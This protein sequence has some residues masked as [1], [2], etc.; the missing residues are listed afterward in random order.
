MNR[1]ILRRVALALIALV[2]FA[3]ASV[4]LAA[5]PMERGAMAQ[6][7]A[8]GSCCD[9]TQLEL[10][11]QLTNGCVAHCT[12]DLQLW[13]M[14]VALVRPPADV[15]VLFVPAAQPDPPTGAGFATPPL[16]APPSR[17]L[18]HSFLI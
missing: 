18:L 1:R 9:T 17:I 6:A 4:A 10:Q 12:A 13:A 8:D 7:A 5:C 11:P 14:P 2:T 15:P 3:Q 16:L